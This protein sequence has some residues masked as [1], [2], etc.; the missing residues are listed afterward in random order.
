MYIVYYSC[1]VFD[2]FL[3]QPLVKDLKVY[4]KQRFDEGSVD[5]Q[6]QAA[7]RDNLSLR[8]LPCMKT[9]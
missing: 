1:K 4:L 5:R 7:I 9:R 3:G 6:L 8:T 2:L